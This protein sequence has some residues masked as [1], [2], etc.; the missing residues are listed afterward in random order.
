MPHARGALDGSTAL[1]GPQHR[2]E[3]RVTEPRLRV[4]A[5]RGLC[6]TDRGPRH[7]ACFRT[8]SRATTRALGRSALRRSHRSRIP[9]DARFAG[10]GARR[11]RRHRPSTYGRRTARPPCTGGTHRIHPH[12]PKKGAAPMLNPVTA[13]PTRSQLADTDEAVLAFAVTSREPDRDIP[14]D[15]LAWWLRLQEQLEIRA[16]LSANGLL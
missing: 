15:E 11:R 2:E 14:E 12:Q 6:L 5:A 8:D 7:V 4:A 1:T 9:A 10:C 3:A 13:N 16:E